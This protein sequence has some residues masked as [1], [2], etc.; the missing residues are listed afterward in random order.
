[1]IEWAQDGVEVAEYL[2]QHLN[3]DRIVLVGHSW[4]SL[5]GL[6]IAKARP[7]LFYAFVGTG[8]VP[9]SSKD[10]NLVAYGLAVQRA[11][12]VKNTQALA[13]LKRVGPPP[14]EDGTGGWGVLYKWRNAC[15]GPDRDVFLASTLYYALAQP[16]YTL[17]DFNYSQDSQLMGE[18]A[19]FD[20]VTNLDRK[21]LEGH[22]DVPY[23]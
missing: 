23:S 20:Q 5:L 11:R 1:L 3:Q 13:D 21:R 12:S 7:D 22:F 10:A 9:S 2:R 18:Q 6:L 15:E 16:G 19:L 8:Q 4:G 14:Y 17:R